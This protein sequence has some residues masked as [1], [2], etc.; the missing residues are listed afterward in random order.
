MGF[1]MELPDGQIKKIEDEDYMVVTLDGVEY[2]VIYLGET[3][4]DVDIRTFY[5]IKDE[6]GDIGLEEV[7]N[8][9]HALRI[10][11]WAIEEWEMERE[12]EYEREQ[13]EREHKQRRGW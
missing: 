5:V 3:D 2:A 11:D 10:W 6:T 13:K 12:A 4:E 7:S 1:E 9:L 8:P